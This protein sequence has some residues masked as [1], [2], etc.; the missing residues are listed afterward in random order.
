MSDSHGLQVSWLRVFSAVARLGSFTAAAR[1]LGYT[2]SAVSRQVCALEGETGARLFDRLPRGVRLT[3]QGRSLL[4]HAEAVLDRL[5]AARRDLEALREAAVGRLRVGAFATANAALV[6][7]AV[8]ALRARHPGL[9]VTT[10]EGLS[11]RLAAALAAGD[12]D[13]A[14]LSAVSGEPPGGLDL[15]PLL[16]DAMFVALPRTHRF[17]DRPRVRLADLAGEEWIAGRR[18][19]EDTLMAAALHAGFRPR[20][21]FVVAEW[22]AKQGFVAAGLG[23]TLV[24]ALA[25]GVARP[26]LAV[27]PLHPD[28]VPPR[29]VYAATARGITPSPAAAAFL[30][31]LR[32]SAAVLRR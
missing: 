21:R 27:V 6:P 23:V 11:A 2:Q 30:A 12:L 17:A 25:A 8:S 15:R 1:E 31:A 28:D 5:D 4:G 7:A 18:D 16:D 14:V 10:R 13:V 26:D 29:A 20:I 24:P 32:D 22:I 3:E 19:P 9:D